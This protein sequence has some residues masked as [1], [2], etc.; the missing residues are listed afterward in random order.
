MPFRFQLDVAA[1]SP[2]EVVAAVLVAIAER[3]GA[4]GDY[5]G[6]VGARVGVRAEASDALGDLGPADWP[7]TCEP[8]RSTPLR[9]P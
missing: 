1:T 9:W 5:S 2:A 6:L 8:R 4:E 3:L 7:P